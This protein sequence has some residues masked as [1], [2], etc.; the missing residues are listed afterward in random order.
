MINNPEVEQI[1]DQAITYAKQR[2]HEYITLEHALLSLVTYAPFREQLDQF[3]V[4]TEGMITDIVVYLDAQTALVSSTDKNPKKTNS[5]ERM[6]NRAVT[7]V[8]FTGRHQIEVIDIYMS[9]L[10]ETNSHAHYFLLKWGVTKQEFLKH[11]QK[12]NRSG[13]DSKMSESTA[14]E[15]LEEYTTNLSELARS[16]KLEPLIGR[17][18]EVDDIVNVLAKKFKA[19]V[20]MVGDP[21]V[22]KTAIV[23]G[24]AHRI[25][26]G[27]I[28][29]FLQDHQVYSLEI[30]SLLAGS[31][32]RGDFEE[33]V[34][35]V[36]EA[37]AA[38]PNCILFIDEAHTMTGAGSS[39]NGGPDFANM[40]KPA[41]TK[42]NLK[43]IASTTWE[44]FYE[45]FE[46]DRAL[47]RR[48][49]R[50]GIDEPDTETTVKILRGLT[51]RLQEFH[52]VA[53]EDEAIDT[54]VEAS[55][56]YIHDR[57]NP[58]KSIDLLDAACAKQRVANNAGAKITADLIS[59]Q[60]ERMTGVPADKLKD[61]TTER[62][63]GLERNVKGKLYGQD[64]TVDQ[65]LDRIYVSFAGINNEKKPMASFLFL[66]PTGT[67]K[68]ELARLLSKS[69]DMPLVKYDMSEY[70]EKHTVSSLIGPPPGYVG[71][72]DN[73]VGGGRLIND[74]S[75][76]PYSI[77]LFD[78]VEKAHPDIFNV[79]L[80]LLDEGRVT[81]SNG[82]VVNAKNTI[83]ILTSNLG[84]ADGERNAIGFGS[85][86]KLGED[87]RALKDFFKPEFR[88]RLDLVCK[89]DKLDT[90]AIKKI[91]VKFTQEL[92]DSL[93]NVHNITL[94]LSEELITHLAEVGYDSKMGARPLSRKIDELIRV[95]LSKKI[96]FERIKDTTVTADYVSEKVE[97]TVA[98][99]LT[100]KVDENGYI[101]VQ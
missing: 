5:L 61:D 83:I 35:A 49:Y 96:L 48:F 51:P 39:S 82:K 54:A 88:N 13:R 90:L 40:I 69:L 74:L 99:K 64:T 101:Q 15:V 50:V 29:K 3:G 63:S 17:E 37:I 25:N 71:F 21:G 23:E 10:T 30:G 8:L 80:Q 77:L 38:K 18:K 89:F 78:E 41:I 85:Q 27:T 44:E 91:V 56:R 84:S 55:A 62:I 42:G 24:L 70:S 16:G 66:G 60:V 57:K 36:M 86:E 9:L 33:K 58:D 52:N 2:N 53:I 28:P 67:G 14:D 59:E 76:N 47:M 20:L 43:I 45:T 73:S 34:K 79:F 22:G 31:K 98:K 19:N 12:T 68:T 87:D 1:L 92:Q 4:D 46:K 26:D 94:N 7:Q 93:K 72:S 65:V 97:F 6:F 11:W 32:Y 100:A 75:K 95:P 81:G